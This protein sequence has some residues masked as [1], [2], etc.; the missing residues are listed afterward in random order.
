MFSE[1]GRG[2]GR[3]QVVRVMMLMMLT[4]RQ[5]WLPARLMMLPRRRQ[6]EG[7]SGTGRAR[8]HAHDAGQ[9]GKGRRT[10]QGKGRGAPR[11]RPRPPSA[12]PSLPPAQ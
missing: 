6:G 7:P 10:D 3:P 5:R 4:G 9:G 2:T 8:T 12:L 11:A 1:V